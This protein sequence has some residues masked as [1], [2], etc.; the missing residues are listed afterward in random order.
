M[1]ILNI[2]YDQDT[3]DI[4]GYQGGDALTPTREIPKGCGR[5][6]FGGDVSIWDPQSHRT[7]YKV[8]VNTKQLVL[9]TNKPLDEKEM[10]EDLEN[11]LVVA[12][13]DFDMADWRKDVAFIEYIKVHM[14]EL[15][16]KIDRLKAEEQ[17]VS[18]LIT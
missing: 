6:A 15:Q 1:S 8:D 2:Y 11:K 4:K 12:K 18:T 17:S 10:L 5:V 16:L 3:G 7:I 13:K 9:I 14:D